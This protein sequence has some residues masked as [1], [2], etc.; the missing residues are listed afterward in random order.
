MYLKG[1]PYRDA[2]GLSQLRSCIH[3]AIINAA[4]IIGG[5]VDKLE[6]QRQCT[7]RRV[8]DTHMTELEKCEYVSSVMNIAPVLNIDREKMGDVGILLEID[9]GVYVCIC[10]VY[11]S[12]FKEV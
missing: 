11:L 3:D 9:D 6:L 2:E 5:N 4:P 1:S 10:T 8:K 7:P 12:V